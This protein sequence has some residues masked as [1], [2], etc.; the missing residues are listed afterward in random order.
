[1]S[2]N[3]NLLE[4]SILFTVE[5]QSS[6][7]DIGDRTSICFNK[8]GPNRGL[9]IFIPSD[10][11]DDDNLTIDIYVLLPRVNSTIDTFTTNLPLFSQKFDDL[12]QYLS[13]GQFSLGGS[14]RLINSTY[15]QASQ[16]VV[17][18]VLSSI[19]G[20]FNVTQSLSLESIR[21]PIIADIMLSPRY[22]QIQPT[23]LILGTGNSTINAS[24]TLNALTTTSIPPSSPNFVAQVTNFDGP[25]QIDVVYGNTSLNSPLQMNVQNNVASSIISMDSTFEGCFNAQ[26]K[27]SRVFVQDNRKNTSW[28]LDYDTSLP[29]IAMGRVSKDSNPPS[30]LDTCHSFVNILSALGPVNLTFVP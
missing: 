29:D 4:S 10:I 26:A 8:E 22:D 6:S 25:I 12:R 3:D 20:S 21:G 2:M 19:Q 27:L 9:S 14:H 1:V 30:Y 15:L 18:N 16:I 28:T 17:T 13:F 11:G 7:K 23:T 24:I 5:M